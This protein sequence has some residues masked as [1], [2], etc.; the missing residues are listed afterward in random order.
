MAMTSEDYMAIEPTDQRISYR[1]YVITYDPPPVPVREWDWHFVHEQF[2]GAPDAGDYRC[3]DAASLTDCM[4]EIDLI[5]DG[6]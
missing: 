1:G 2:D 5:E 3:G 6:V 4:C